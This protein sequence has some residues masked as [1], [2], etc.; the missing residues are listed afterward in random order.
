METLGMSWNRL[1]SYILEMY[2][3]LEGR[4]VLGKGLDIVENR[5]L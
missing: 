4:K 2:E 5:V 3:L 1:E